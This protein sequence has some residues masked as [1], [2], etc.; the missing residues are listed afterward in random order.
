V[1]AH[2]GVVVREINDCERELCRQLQL[3]KKRPHKQRLRACGVVERAIVAGAGAGIG[4]GGGFG[5]RH[6]GQYAV[7]EEHVE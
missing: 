3:Y 2:P 7:D 5:K 4:G 6:S 1:P